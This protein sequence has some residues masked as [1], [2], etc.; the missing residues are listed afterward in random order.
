MYEDVTIALEGFQI[1]TYARNLWP[2]S[3]EGSLACH[4][5]CD[6]G[7]P[8]IMIISEIFWQYHLECNYLFLQLKW[9]TNTQPSACGA[10]ALTRCATAAILENDHSS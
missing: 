9:D 5:Y 8:F 4:T 1:L 7:H 10:N 6:T 2:L 3:S